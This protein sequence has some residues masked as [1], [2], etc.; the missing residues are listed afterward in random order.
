MTRFLII[1]AVALLAAMITGGLLAL[2][3]I[4]AAVVTAATCAASL[5][6]HYVLSEG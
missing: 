3:Q 6:C 4:L 2:G 5:I 1:Y